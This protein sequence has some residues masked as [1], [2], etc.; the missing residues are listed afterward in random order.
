MKRARARLGFVAGAFD[1]LLS[2]GVGFFTTCLQ[3][4]LDRQRDFQRQGSHLFQQQPANRCVDAL[5]GILWQIAL[6][7]FDAIALTHV[8]RH[9]NCLAAIVANRHPF[10]AETAHSQT[11]QQGRPFA[12][13]TL[14]AVAAERLSILRQL[15]N[16]ALDTDPK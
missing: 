8:T 13:R 10:A 1:L 11:L 5:P 4:L 14:A 2:Q 6:A 15:P 3:F 12:R 7:L 9:G 16:V